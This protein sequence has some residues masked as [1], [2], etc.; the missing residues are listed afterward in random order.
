MPLMHGFETCEK[1]KNSKRYKNNPAPVIAYMR[2]AF[3]EVKEKVLENNMDG[4]IGK[5]FTQAHVI[6]SLINILA[7]HGV[8][9]ESVTNSVIK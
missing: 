1:L 2:F 7:R 4:Y 6:S 3:E 5:P 9:A 8:I